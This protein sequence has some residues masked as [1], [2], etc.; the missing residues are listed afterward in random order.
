MLT[1][2]YCI[3]PQHTLDATSRRII[4]YSDDYEARRRLNLDAF[5]QAVGALKCRLDSIEERLST[6]SDGARW[7]QHRLDPTDSSIPA[8]SIL[9]PLPIA[10]GLHLAHRG[11]PG[12][13]SLRCHIHN[14]SHL[15]SQ[16]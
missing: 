10:D 13:P 1:L 4:D 3:G 7:L 12:F 11:P 15:G 16:D 8:S 14:D 9:A 6:L 5:L 2:G